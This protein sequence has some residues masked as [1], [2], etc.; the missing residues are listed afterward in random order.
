MDLCQKLVLN[1]ILNP[2]IFHPCKQK[3]IHTQ[4]SHGSLLVY[5]GHHKWNHSTPACCKWN[6]KTQVPFPSWNSQKPAMSQGSPQGWCVWI[7]ALH[8]KSKYFLNDKASSAGRRSMRIKYRKLFSIEWQSLILFHRGTFRN[9]REVSVLPCT[10]AGGVGRVY[11]WDK[12]ALYG[13]VTLRCSWRQS[14]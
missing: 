3:N 4:C 13:S 2:Y 5:R 12:A 9:P 11:L 14:F 10:D 7:E 1:V 6:G 8:N